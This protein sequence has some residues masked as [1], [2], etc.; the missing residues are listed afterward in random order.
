MLFDIVSKTDGVKFI[1]KFTSPSFIYKLIR[2]FNTPESREREIL[3]E[4]VY[5]IY[6][7]KFEYIQL[8]LS[9]TEGR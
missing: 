6:C 1:E 9:V 3:K 7:K 2:N 5:K 8:E 4:I